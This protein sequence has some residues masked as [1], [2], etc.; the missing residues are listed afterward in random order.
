MP[1]TKNKHAQQH[2]Q[3]R[4]DSILYPTSNPISI[5]DLPSHSATPAF[6]SSNDVIDAASGSNY[7]SHQYDEPE[8]EQTE[9]ETETV[10]V[11]RP[12]PSSNPNPHPSLIPHHLNSHPQVP[13][14]W[15]STSTSVN[16]LDH[17]Q[18][19]PSQFDSQSSIQY[20]Q[21]QPQLPAAYLSDLPI[22]IH[23][24]SLPIQSQSRPH[25]LSPNHQQSLPIPQS[26][27]TSSAHPNPP[28]LATSNS[29]LLPPTYDAHNFNS[30]PPQ[31][32][33]QEEA[34]GGGGRFPRWT[35]WLEKRA[36][37]RHYNRLDSNAVSREL[38][39]DDPLK[40]NEELEIKYDLN[41]KP[42]L[43]EEMAKRLAKK[44]SW[45]K[46]RDDG[47]AIS[48]EEEKLERQNRERRSKDEDRP[49]SVE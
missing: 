39:L 44:K 40:S 3:Q 6:D 13:S 33:N 4:S 2:Q 18:P 15:Q 45:G 22:P 36:L 16:R 32:S 35:G 11:G 30:N 24:Q 19:H 7:L 34:S 21:H 26:P 5:F 43:N 27:P 10:L 37:E 14:I 25:H 9:R 48:D 38:G 20:H 49:V 8:Q 41:G 1:Q 23:Q 31:L 47:D 28:L 12:S 29:G 46:N 17:I 42:V